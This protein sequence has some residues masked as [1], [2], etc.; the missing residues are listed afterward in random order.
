MQEPLGSEVI[1]DIKVND[2]LIKV[3]ESP[4]FKLEVGDD[5]WLSFDYNKLHLFDEKTGEAII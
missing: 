4:G 5:V 3:K 1:V 2:E